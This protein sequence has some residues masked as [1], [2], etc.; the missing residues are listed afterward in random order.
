MPSSQALPSDKIVSLWKC[1][2]VKIADFGS[3]VVLNRID[4]SEDG[5]GDSALSSNDN[6]S[7]SSDSARSTGE[8]GDRTLHKVYR[9]IRYFKR[10]LHRLGEAEE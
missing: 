10:Y 9:N 7:G 5:D 2:Q 1:T 8:E 4:G 6:N 3:C